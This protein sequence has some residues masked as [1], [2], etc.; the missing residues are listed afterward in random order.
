MVNK[1][2]FEMERRTVLSIDNNLD[3]AEDVNLLRSTLIWL[4]SARFHLFN[5]QLCVSNMAGFDSTR[6]TSNLRLKI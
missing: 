4:H 1:R 2:R 5:V 6:L 3:P